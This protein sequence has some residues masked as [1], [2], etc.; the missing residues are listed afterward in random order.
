MI[1]IITIN[2]NNINGLLET[3]K[4]VKYQTYQDWSLLIVDG[5]STDGSEQLQFFDRRITFICEK[6]NGIYDA[7]NKAISLLKHKGHTIFLNS[8]DV[9]ADIN[10]LKRVV[11][12][13]VREDTVYYGSI[14][15]EY[16]TYCVKNSPRPLSDYWKEKPFHHQAA[17]YPSY[18]LQQSMFNTAFRYCADYDQFRTLYSSGIKFEKIDSLISRVE[19]VSG[20]STILKNFVIVWFENY[21]ISSQFNLSFYQ[22]FWHYMSFVRRLMVKLF[23]DLLV[24]IARKIKNQ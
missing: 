5:L 13:L 1:N 17:F 15:S 11:S 24:K 16:R 14:I 10:V 20:S 22:H 12:N 8:G 18:V 9:F 3:F 4:S 21:T 19:R 2:R 23:P 7:M 6:D